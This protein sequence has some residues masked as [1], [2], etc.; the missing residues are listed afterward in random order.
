MNKEALIR[1]EEEKKKRTGKLD[2]SNLNLVKFLEK[3]VKWFG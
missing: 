2:L 1:I 3:W